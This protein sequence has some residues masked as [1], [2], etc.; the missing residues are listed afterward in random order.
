M[1]GEKLVK[2]EKIRKKWL[3]TLNKKNSKLNLN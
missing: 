1:L 3:E 2:K